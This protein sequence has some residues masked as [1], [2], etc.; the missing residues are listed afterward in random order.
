MRAMILEGDAAL[1]DRLALTL[2]GAGFEVLPL[3]AIGPAK[4]AARRSAVDVL[5]LGEMVAGRLAHDVALLA[6][7]RNPGLA[8]I[9]ISDRTGEAVAELFDLIPSLQAVMGRRIDWEM[10]ARI[11]RG[12][13]RTRGVGRPGPAQTPGPEGR[14]VTSRSAA[15]TRMPMPR[16]V[17][18]AA[19]PGFP[20]DGGRMP[21]VARRLHLA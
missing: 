17:R 21:P 18:A 1:R 3:G 6:E 16:S 5:V 4:E 8:V 7:W 11:A 12:A 15:P 13:V 9:L 19:A 14:T 2:A 10:L 20:V